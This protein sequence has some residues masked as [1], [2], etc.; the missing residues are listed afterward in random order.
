MFLNTYDEN[1]SLAGSH[2]H[3]LPICMLCS[4]SCPIYVTT[5]ILYLGIM[6]SF[7]RAL[8]TC[9]R[10]TRLDTSGELSLQRVLRDLVFWDREGLCGALATVP[11]TVGEPQ[12]SN[13]VL[14]TPPAPRTGST[15]AAA[16]LSQENQHIHLLKTGA[17]SCWTTEMHAQMLPYVNTELS[18]VRLH[19][20]LLTTGGGRRESRQCRFFNADELFWAKSAERLQGQDS[21]F[22]AARLD[23]TEELARVSLCRI[24]PLP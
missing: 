10:K 2:R 20:H 14:Q 9:K 7:T 23:L 5:T 17:P 12:R 8:I 16:V 15:D 4:F 13:R 6:R 24:Q 1:V 3:R 18:S 11:M 22:S 19:G 21:L